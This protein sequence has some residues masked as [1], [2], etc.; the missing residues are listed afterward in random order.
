MNIPAKKTYWIT[1][2]LFV[3]GAIIAFAGLVVGSA[4]W[5]TYAPTEAAREFLQM[6]SE[7]KR[8]EAYGTT[9]LLFQES[10]PQAQLDTFLQ[11]FPILTTRAKAAFTSRNVENNKAFVSGTITGEDGVVSPIT[12]ALVKEEGKWKVLNV[13]L[14]P[15]DTE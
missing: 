4:F 10:V 11:E 7:D 1:A 6:L 12:I 3:V 13:D 5:A 9:S 8:E 2:A 15:M 14:N